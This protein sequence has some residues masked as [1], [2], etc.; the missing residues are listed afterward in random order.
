MFNGSASSAERLSGLGTRLR[1]GARGT[2]VAG[3]KGSRVRIG[4]RCP[5]CKDTSTVE[6]GGS[7]HY[8]WNARCLHIS[9]VLDEYRRLK[10]K[11]QQQAAEDYISRDDDDPYE[12]RRIEV[13]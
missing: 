2:A 9:R 7:Y 1:L 6:D 5:I 4:V 8:V 12:P 11:E 3:A 13:R 10:Y